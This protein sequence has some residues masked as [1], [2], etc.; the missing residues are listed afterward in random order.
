VAHIVPVPTL[1]K[2][3]TGVMTPFQIMRRRLTVTGGS[4]T[5]DGVSKMS[6]SDKDDEQTGAKVSQ[7]L[8][9]VFMVVMRR[10]ELSLCK[11]M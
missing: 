10:S 4:E 8:S 9:S 1:Y 6:V 7:S 11:P 2:K 5:I 3:A